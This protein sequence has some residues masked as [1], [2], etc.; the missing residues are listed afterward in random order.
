[1][2]S[3][4]IA[5]SL[6]TS[7]LDGSERSVSFL[8]AERVSGTHCIESWV[9]PRANLDAVEKRKISWSCWEFNSDF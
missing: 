5:P 7:A 9:D 1:M 6:L 8:A 2:K 4:G 3:R